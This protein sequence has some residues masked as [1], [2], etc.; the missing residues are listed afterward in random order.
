MLLPTIH[1]TAS[2]LNVFV[3]R[4]GYGKPVTITITSYH[5]SE[6]I[7]KNL[8]EDLRVRFEKERAN[9][10]A[11]AKAAGESDEGISVDSAKEP[12]LANNTTDGKEANSMANSTE[13]NSTKTEEPEEPDKRI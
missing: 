1:I 9:L 12:E 3:V 8:P 4:E 5:A 7:M 11:Q 6:K 2:M 13:A 10:T